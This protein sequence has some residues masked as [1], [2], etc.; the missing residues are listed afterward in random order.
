[1][2]SFSEKLKSWMD[3]E[4]LSAAELAPMLGKKTQTVANWRSNGVP[5]S[6]SLRGM[7]SNFMRNYKP[8]GST[9]KEETR[10]AI[11][12]TDDDYSLVE[13]AA[14]LSD[15]G[16][17]AFVRIAAIE[18]A[19]EDIAEDKK[20]NPP[21]ETPTDLYVYAKVADDGKDS[22]PMPQQAPV[23]YQTRK[24]NAAK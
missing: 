13:K 9:K 5:K 8:V 24:S 19:Q 21:P 2:D 1:M 4:E 17:P 11:P 3:I 22:I 23:T 14:R 15:L 20:K 10:I 7:L 6:E 18:R 12:F 16:T